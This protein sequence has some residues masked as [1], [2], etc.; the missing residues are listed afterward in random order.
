MIFKKKNPKELKFC[1]I[2]SSKLFFIIIEYSETYFDE[3]A[4]K[5][6]KKFNN[7]FIYGD[8]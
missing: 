3:A 6:G 7:L 4:S 2:S 8:I 1:G 5:I